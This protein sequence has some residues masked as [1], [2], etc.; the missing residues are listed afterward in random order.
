MELAMWR[1]LAG[2]DI[3]LRTGRYSITLMMLTFRA[4]PLV[5]S[6]SRATLLLQWRRSLAG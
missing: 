1:S 5:H 3:S 2:I 6:F 4:I